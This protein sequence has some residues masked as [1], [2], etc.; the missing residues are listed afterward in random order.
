ML[1]K[2]NYHILI[3]EDNPGDFTLIEEFLLEQIEAP[4]I[5][6]ASTFKEA[7]E[8]LFFKA[9]LFD[10]ILLDLSLPDCTGILLIKE[11]IAIATNAPVIVLTGYADLNFGVRSLS[12]GIS[13]YLLKDEL[14]S[15]TLYR[16]IVYN[17]ERKKTILE[18]AESEKK[19]SQLFQLSPLPMFVFDLETSIF[20]DVNDAFIKNYGY[21]REEMLQ[22]NLADIKLTETITGSIADAK[23]RNGV[24]GIA[25]HVKKNGEVIHVDLQSNFIRYKGRKAQITI[26]GDI[27]ERLSYINAIEQQNEKLREISWMQSHIVRAPLARI[28]G[29]VEV[30]RELK[31]N[32]EEKEMTLDFLMSSANELDE[33]IKKI[34][35]KIAV[36]DDFTLQK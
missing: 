4:L 29:L 31:D 11:V 10:L 5:V 32:D 33:V 2:G 22:M 17:L 13:D 30:I 16:S 3:I 35:D 9:T 23:R 34:T 27:T 20:L 26:A 15:I 1:N 7:Y 8:I 25:K 6:Q 12:L 19:Y 36:D 28:M 14:T 21:T 18:L 24:S